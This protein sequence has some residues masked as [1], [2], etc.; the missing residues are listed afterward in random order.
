MDASFYERLAQLKNR[1][2]RSIHANVLEFFLKKHHGNIED[3]IA[4]LHH[5]GWFEPRFT[6]DRKPEDSVRQEIDYWDRQ[7]NL[8]DQS[9][10]VTS[11]QSVPNHIYNPSAT[12]AS[13]SSSQPGPQD[14]RFNIIGQPLDSRHPLSHPREY[15]FQV[16]HPP[17]LPGYSSRQPVAQHQ[18]AN[19]GQM[20]MQSMPVNVPYQH[21]VDRLNPI[22]LSPPSNEKTKKKMSPAAIERIL[23]SQREQLTKAK[24]EYK[25]TMEELDALKL[26]IKDKSNELYR[27]KR[28]NSTTSLP[29][30]DE[31]DFEE[32]I[33]KTLKDD[34]Q[35]ETK[36]I[37][38]KRGQNWN[39]ISCRFINSPLLIQCEVCG[40]DR[41]DPTGIVK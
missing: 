22:P 12:N 25:K 33:I 28:H 9:R 13:P 23:R 41:P 7:R 32:T 5:S 34:I 26:K 1:V 4:D 8:P 11:Q 36:K 2:G 18:F 40:T 16:S 17:L 15:S 31:I 24:E 14:T 30:D 27:T 21:Q 6:N 29:P 20:P 19:T 37:V 3:C 10:A 38:K 39:C 35:E